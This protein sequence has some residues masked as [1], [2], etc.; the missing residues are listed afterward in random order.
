MPIVSAIPLQLIPGFTKLVGQYLTDN[1]ALRH[2]YK[3]D[4]NIDAFTQ[5]IADKSNDNTDR[6]LLV[7]VLKKQYVNVTMTEH[8]A[9]NIELLHAGTTFT[10][11]AAHQPCVLLGPVFN[12]YKIA[13]TINLANQLKAKYPEHNFVPVFWMGSEDHDF[14]ELGTTV[15]YGKKIEWP[16]GEGE[17]GA[18]GRR[19][20]QSFEKVLDEALAILGE[21]AREFIDKLREGLTKFKTF[22]PYTRYLINELFGETGLVVIDQD[23]AELKQKFSPIIADELKNSSAIKAIGST[24]KWLNDN[25]TI[26]ATPR[27]I[28]LFYLGD[29]SRERIIKSKD[30]YEVNN[31]ALTFTE[32][33]ILELAS[34]KPEL[35]SPNVILRPVYQEL[36][37]P[38]LAF[39]GG[40]GELS[41]WMELKSVFEY[42]K[43]NYPMLV[44][45]ASMT[46]INNGIEKKMIKLGLTATDFL[47]NIDQ[48][49]N[50]FVK[51]KLSD[52]I[53]FE[54]E[55]RNVALMFDSF[56]D[57]AEKVDPTLKATVQAEKQKQ[58][59]ALD[60]LEGKIVK[61]EKR[62]Q[63]ESIN[64][65]RSISQTFVPDQSWQERIEN[66]LSFYVKDKSFVDNSVKL[67]NP[68]SRD[69][70]IVN[71]DR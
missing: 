13:S 26:Q 10:V 46:M 54:E 71:Q 14:E 34:S 6:E 4:F 59:N 16:A 32:A 1:P 17:G 37:L 18:F 49:I 19:R 27:D 67:A 55:K 42:H 9:L 62:K 63:E 50:S 8:T 69:M 21:P 29:N 30:A 51:S 64:Q 12:I 38:N 66:F 65:I 44:M 31:T 35:F 43:V 33:E 47:G 28:N 45:R 24:I 58:L 23:D 39:I 70:L 52:D 22:G 61:A 7:R 57:K 11:T 68:F 20:M 2:L 40:A 3:Y 41:Y 56:S 15:I 36:I 53:H 48:T 60:A 5:I 25:Y